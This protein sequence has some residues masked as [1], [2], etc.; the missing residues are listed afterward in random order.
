L[1]VGLVDPASVGHVNCNLKNQ[2]LGA[3]P[4]IIE[5]RIGIAGCLAAVVPHICN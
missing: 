3:I 4:D 1:W 2:R 5:F